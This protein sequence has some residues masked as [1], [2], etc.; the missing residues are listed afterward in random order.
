MLKKALRKSVLATTLSLSA[1]SAQ[2]ADISME[3]AGASSVVGIMPQTM[4]TYLA[5]ADVNV[6]LAMGQTLTKSLLKVAD[7]KLDSAVIPPGAYNALMAGKGPYAKIGAEKGAEM[8]KNVSALYGLPGSTFH[9]ITWADNGIENWKDAA[10]KR[11]YIGPPAGAANAQITSL[12]EAGG[13]AKDTYEGIKAPWGAAAQAFQDGQFDVYVGTFPVGSQVVAELSL[14]R[15]I[16]I[17]GIPAGTQPKKG[18]GMEE[19][20]IPAGTYPNQA[21]K[22]D[23]GTFVTLM[24]MG[25]N[26]DMSDDLAYTMTKVYMDSREQMG[27]DNRLL[28]HLSK[29]SPFTGVTARLHPGAIKYYEEHGIEVPANLK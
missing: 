2:A 6:Q 25:V 21:N 16:R 22:T 7:G 12:A 19:A 5:A 14:K 8:A 29:Y 23:S 28:S 18:L 11:V 24:F 4:A 9:A 27:K 20:N 17:L 3:A 26:T 10:G 13:L 1:I 15:P